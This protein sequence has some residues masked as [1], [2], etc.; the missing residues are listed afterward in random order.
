LNSSDDE[1]AKYLKHKTHQEISNSWLRDTMERRTW[2]VND[3][4][5]P[6]FIDAF[7]CKICERLH[8]NIDLRNSGLEHIQHQAD[9][10]HYGCPRPTRFSDIPP[11]NLK[12]QNFGDFDYEWER[13]VYIAKAVSHLLLTKKSFTKVDVLSLAREFRKSGNHP[14]L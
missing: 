9:V 4:N 14:D 10:E 8:E 5:K 3:W 11:G 2:G 1:Y 6:N 7:E 13:S 12:R